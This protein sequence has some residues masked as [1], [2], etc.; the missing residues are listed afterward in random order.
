MENKNKAYQACLFYLSRRLYFSFELKKKLIE[1]GFDPED[2]DFAVQKSIDGLVINDEDCFRFFIKDW[3][4]IKRKGK[5]ALIAKLREKGV[6]KD[7]ISEMIDRYY[8]MEKEI[9]NVKEWICFKKA[10]QSITTAKAENRA[11]IERFLYQRGF[12]SN[13]YRKELEDDR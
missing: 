10:K 13:T 6:P 5:I 4:D 11:K 9:K 12:L 7:I 8:D 3:Q 1:N 2:A